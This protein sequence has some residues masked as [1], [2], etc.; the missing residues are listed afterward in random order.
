[1]M[2]T[3]Q[4]KNKASSDLAGF[5]GSLWH[6]WPWTTFDQTSELVWVFW[7]GTKLVFLIL[8]GQ[9]STDQTGWGP[10]SYKSD[11]FRCSSGFRAWTG[12]IS[13]YTPLFS[14]HVIQ[15]HS[16]LYHLYAD[17]SQLYDY[18]SFSSDDSLS[19]LNSL[20]SCLGSGW[21]WTLSKKLK[22]ETEFLLIDHEQ[23]TPKVL[24]PCFQ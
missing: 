24:I 20:K 9:E 14:A 17:D 1:M 6:H 10:L 7:S 8:D 19:Q 22:V 12:V 13:H 2:A 5:L 11:S 18:V 15:G 23:Q 4:R 3:D 21:N 16:I